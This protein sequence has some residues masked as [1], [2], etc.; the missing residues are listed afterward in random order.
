[1]V[2]LCSVFTG[3]V[4]KTLHPTCTGVWQR[5]C[6]PDTGL[7]VT[8]R[9]IWWDKPQLLQPWQV[10][11]DT[12][13][14][15]PEAS[16][17]TLDSKPHVSMA[18]Y[19]IHF[20]S[21]WLS[22][23]GLHSNIEDLCSI[24]LW[25]WRLKLIS[26]KQQCYV[27]RWSVWLQIHGRNLILSSPAGGIRTVTLRSFQLK[28]E[29]SETIRILWPH[30]SLL[31]GV[32]QPSFS[33]TE[34]LTFWFLPASLE[35]QKKPTVPTTSVSKLLQ[36]LTLYILH[37]FGICIFGRSHAWTYYSWWSSEEYGHCFGCVPKIKVFM[38]SSTDFFFSLFL[39]EYIFFYKM[40]IF[41]FLSWI[42]EF[43]L[44]GK[45]MIFLLKSLLIGFLD[46]TLF[47]HPFIWAEKRCVFFFC[48]LLSLLDGLIM[49]LWWWEFI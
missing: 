13:T 25:N 19:G 14:M 3:A 39:W 42:K 47:A 48:F 49:S 23:L 41:F 43:S 17:V 20:L 34:N 30:C 2:K 32:R 45:W 44:Q 40:I 7:K 35:V 46:F 26:C 33:V 27:S 1:M 21:E 15:R 37:S 24:L 38:W 4:M 29:L 22:R 8:S 18:Y 12:D 16:R 36:Q 6:S 5:S 10:Q 28:N 9:V 11:P 31:T